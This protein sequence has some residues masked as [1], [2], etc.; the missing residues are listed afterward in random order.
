MDH[1]F[2]DVEEWEEKHNS[3]KPASASPIGLFDDFGNY[4]NRVIVQYHDFFTRY[5]SSFAINNVIDQCVFHAHSHGVQD[6][7]V[8]FYD[9]H[10]HEIDGDDDDTTTAAP[11]IIPKFTHKR[12]PDY[13]SLRPLFGWLSPDIIKK[14]FENTTQYARIP[15]GTLLKRT[16]K[17]PNPALNVAQRHEAVVCDI[18]YSDTPAVNDGSTAAVLFVGME[19]QVIDI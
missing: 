18:V 16:F 14:T 11:I 2:K 9:A 12:N 8:F 3:P 10:E 1:E 6:D 13:A 19:S 15:T 7:I 5:G 17:S 4:R